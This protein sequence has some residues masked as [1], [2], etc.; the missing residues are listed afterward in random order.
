MR[1]GMASNIE[2]ISD[3]EWIRCVSSIE[4]KYDLRLA[5]AIQFKCWSAD[6]TEKIIDEL[7]QM[8]QGG[9]K[10]AAWRAIILAHSSSIFPPGWATMHLSKSFDA[11]IEDP[12]TRYLT[13]NP[14]RKSGGNQSSLADQYRTDYSRARRYAA[15]L[16]ADFV[17][18]KD[19]ARATEAKWILNYQG[20]IRGS[21]V[22]TLKK[23]WGTLMREKHFGVIP[24]SEFA[25]FL[26]FAHIS[27]ERIKSD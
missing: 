16:V 26:Y 14:I 19:N 3:D 8:Y 2:V 12:H 13:G 7:H 27:Y 22:S 25:G 18:H 21:G 9:Y 5:L 11:Y 20:Y 17:G 6:H 23:L 24:A 1:R 10:L 15:L 4:E